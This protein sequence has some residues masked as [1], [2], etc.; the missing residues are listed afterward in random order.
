MQST[1]PNG[2][3]RSIEECVL[4]IPNVDEL[5]V[6]NNLPDISDSKSANYNNEPIMGRSYPLYTYHF[7]GDRN[8]SIKFHFYITKKGDGLKNLQTL[9]NIQSAVYPRKSQDDGAPFRPPV[10]CTFKCKSLLAKEPL[11]MVLRDYSVTFPT[12]VAWEEETYCPYKFDLDT[13]WLVVYTSP[14]LRTQVE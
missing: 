10:I 11:C 4:N 2:D 8:I 3:L 13:N 1:L 5:I 6:L 14:D 7:S 12:D 9:R